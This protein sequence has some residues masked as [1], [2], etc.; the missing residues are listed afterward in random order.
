MC[1]YGTWVRIQFVRIQILR[2]WGEELEDIDQELSEIE[3]MS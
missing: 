2:R 3:E 1:L